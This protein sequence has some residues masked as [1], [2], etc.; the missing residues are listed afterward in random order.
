[1]PIT[2]GALGPDDDQVGLDLPRRADHGADVQGVERAK[3]S[4][5][6]DADVAG[7]ADHLG[8]ARRPVQRLDDRVLTGAGAEH[9]HALGQA[10]ARFLAPRHGVAW[11]RTRFNPMKS[12]IGIALRVS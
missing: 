1:M 7:R 4:L 10:G 2:S 12:S 8:A 6:G 9:E 5:G 11:G 3:R